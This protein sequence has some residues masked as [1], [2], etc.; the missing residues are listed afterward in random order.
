MAVGVGQVQVGPVDAPAAVLHQDHGSVG[1]DALDQGHVGQRVV[2]A[3]VPVPV[4]GVVE[5]DQVAGVGAVPVEAAAA[6]DVAVDDGD[7]VLPAVGGAV[8]E[9]VDALAAVDR[10]GEARAV[11]AVAVPVEPEAPAAHQASGEV[12]EG[13]LAGED[14]GPGVGD[15]P[16]GLGGE[17]GEGRGGAGGP[18]G[19]RGGGRRRGG[20][21]RGRRGV[22]GRRGRGHRVL[23]PAG[24]GGGVQGGAHRGHGAAAGEEG[25]GG[26]EDQARGAA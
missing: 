7:A 10:L 17:A 9:E 18:G 16:G 21:R 20:H 11:G 1:A 14:P 24:E 12:G 5:E 22:V 3:P 15:L 6:P 13:V 8:G 19:G 26:E 25:G 23:E 4:E 2:P